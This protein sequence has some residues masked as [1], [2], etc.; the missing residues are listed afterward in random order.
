MELTDGARFNSP[1]QKTIF[2]EYALR[3]C[4]QKL[5]I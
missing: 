2:D 3:Q 1:L 5:G 4:S